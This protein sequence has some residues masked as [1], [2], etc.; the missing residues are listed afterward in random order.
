LI[1]LAL[2]AIGTIVFPSAA[3]TVGPIGLLVGGVSAGLALIMGARR[4]ETREKISWMF[5]G[6]GLLLISTGVVAFAVVSSLGSLA[7]FGPPDLFL[8]AGYGVGILGF[9]LLPQMATDWSQRV[10]AI[11]DA[12]IGAV[13]IGVMSWLLVLGDLLGKLQEYSAWD[14]WA[15]S[16]YPILD[17]F[18]MV[19]IIVVFLRRNSYR[20]DIRLWLAALAFVAQSIADIAYLTSGVGRTFEQARP[21]FALNIFAL[22]LFLVV[23]LIVGAQ[24][25]RREYADRQTSPAVLLAPYALALGMATMLSVKAFEHRVDSDFWALLFGTLFVGALT[26][27]RQAVSIRE[28]RIVVDRE[29]EALVSSIS[30][31]LRTPLTAIVGFLDLVVD[32]GTV[33]AEE[34]EE[35]LQVVHQ[36]AVYMARIVSDLV[37]LARGRLEAIDLAPSRVPLQQLIISALAGIDKAGASVSVEV[38][39]E[40]I[41]YVDSERIQQAIVNLVSNAIRYGGG[42]V[43]VVAR[44]DDGAFVLEVHDDGSGVPTKYEY[45]IWE[46]FERG[47][48][49]LDAIRPG[50]GIGL[51]IVEAVARAHGGTA[52]YSRSNRLGGACFTVTLPRRIVDDTPEPAASGA[53][54]A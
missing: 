50:S 3:E 12:S 1:L 26:I 48:H 54:P 11:L 13:S 8:L 7:A 33:E 38:D 23:G 39:P 45:T 35:L 17:A 24:P 43:D 49:R 2:L 36:Q 19:A 27:I 20:F 41:V 5:V 4:L 51:A 10:R 52:R 6:T 14:R 16:A 29:R 31:E 40:A 44:A 22:M 9:G 18:A 46:Q 21:V 53:R 34:R 25:R 15:G 32:A 37:A 28:N 30:H 47:A 42:R